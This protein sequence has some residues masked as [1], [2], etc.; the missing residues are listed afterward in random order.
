MTGGRE[1]ERAAT[2]ALL[3]AEKAEYVALFE[4]AQAH[5]SY[6]HPEG[7]RKW[8]WYKFAALIAMVNAHP[9][10][11]GLDLMYDRRM[12]EEIVAV[13]DRHERLE[14]PPVPVFSE[15]NVDSAQE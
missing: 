12:A 10:V 2:R 5:L 7:M 15:P 14:M 1:A 6:V 8:V 13:V 9:S 3:E 11:L 4:R